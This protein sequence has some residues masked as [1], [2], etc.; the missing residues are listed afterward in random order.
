MGMLGHVP[1]LFRGSWYVICCCSHSLM[2]PVFCARVFDVP[3]F[4]WLCCLVSCHLYNYT[5]LLSG[6]LQLNYLMFIVFS[7]F[8][9]VFGASPFH[10]CSVVWLRC[11]VFL[12]HSDTVWCLWFSV[13]TLFDVL[14]LLIS[15]A[16]SITNDF[17]KI[18]KKGR[19][20]FFSLVLVYL[21]IC[22]PRFSSSCLFMFDSRVF[23]GRTRDTWCPSAPENDHRRHEYCTHELLS[24]NAWGEALATGQ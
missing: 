22:M 12:I 13:A 3:C 7:G 1:L 16:I 9:D 21:M 24:W 6:F 4:V 5:C 20:F 17:H 18:S 2:F 23:C 15:V 19:N 10:V 8:I 14:Q 11:L